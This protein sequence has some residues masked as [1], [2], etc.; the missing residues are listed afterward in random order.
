MKRLLFI[1]PLLFVATA[2]MAVPAK[3]GIWK[4]VR[5]A[6]GTEVRVTLRG[7]EHGHYWVADDGRM[8]LES[9]NGVYRQV[10]AEELRI[11]AAKRRTAS[12][13][14]RAKRMP[15]RKKVG[16]VGNYTGQKKGIIILVSFSDL[17]FRT[18][19]DY[20]RRIVNE[21]N[22]SDGNFCGSM[23]DYFKAQSGGQFEL[24]FDVVGPVKVSKKASYYGANDIYGDDKYPATMVI[25]ALKLADSQVNYA[26]YDWDGDGEVDQVYVV[27]AGKG[28]ADGGAESTIWP[29]EYALSAAGYYGDGSGRQFLDG[30]WIDT[31]ACGS[32]Q[33]GSGILA[34]I[35]TMCHEFSHC[36]GYPDFYDTDYSGGQGMFEWD[37][38]DQGSY[39]NN[40]YC[41]AGYTAYERWVAGWTTPI[42]LTETL[43]VDSLQASQNG[44]E[45]YIIYNPGERNEFFLMENRQ[46]V[47]WDRYIPG[48]GLLIMHVDYD[49]TV[50]ANNQPNDDPKH[51]RMTWIPADN[52]YQSNYY[53]YTTSGAANDPFPYNTKRS[54]D[55]TT[56]P[57]AKF[58][59]MST[60]GTYYMDSS[61]KNITR[62]NDG[63][64]SF[65]F[66]LPIMG[67]GN[68]A[69]AIEDVVSSSVPQNAVVYDLCGRKVGRMIDGRWQLDGGCRPSGVYI[70]GGRK[71]VK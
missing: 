36:L 27:Y 31:Y 9:E 54:F 41:P 26:D 20:F 34:G 25:E 44:G 4:N 37:L 66:E 47:G 59:N 57:A 49:E 18:S 58:Y 33:N 48:K 30:V 61:V 64:I 13:A 55:K 15:A 62:N 6:D 3:R 63:T 29:H 32:E 46:K 51:Q 52:I 14:R 56:K 53:G 24:T 8:Y 45:S 11:H 28:E 19:A 1:L 42:E 2:I 43:Q 7:D 10:E 22:F 38:M 17:S 21:E 70:V 50:W 68:G 65:L 16:E 71:V 60:D 69:D 12:N 67:G 35:G 5:L 39:N 23:S 40:G